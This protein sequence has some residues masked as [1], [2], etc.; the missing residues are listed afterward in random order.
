MLKKEL[1]EPRK[2]SKLE[3]PHAEA[4]YLLMPD[5]GQLAACVACE[6]TLLRDRTLGPEEWF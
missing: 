3:P 1:D 6:A 5:A 4:A 2:A